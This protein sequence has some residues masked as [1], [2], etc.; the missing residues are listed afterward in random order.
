MTASDLFKVEYFL[1]I[2]LKMKKG[3]KPV[4]KDF[5]LKFIDVMLGIVLGL[6]FQWWPDL[7]EPWQYIAFIFVYINLVDYWI[8]YSPTIKKFPLKRE[9]DVLLHTFI[10]FSMFYL[11]FTT[12]SE[13]I[14]T[15]LFAFIIYRVFDVTWIWRMSSEYNPNNYDKRFLSSWNLFDWIEIAFTATLAILVYF[16]SVNYLLIIMLFILLR[17]TT[18]IMASLRYKAVYF[19]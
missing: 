4:L 16:L 18:R 1:I 19:S 2:I 6:G 7:I 5:S 14:T 13:S 11:V 15:F 17:I 8:D 9:V 12:Q 3:N 10:I